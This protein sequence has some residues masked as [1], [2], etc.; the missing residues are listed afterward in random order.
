MTDVWTMIAEERAA[1]YDGLSK[2]SEEDWR[3]P[4][5]CAGWVVQDVVA[6]MTATAYT[7]QGSF[8]KNFLLS[9]FNFNRMVAKDITTYSA[10]KTPQ[11]MLVTYGTRRQSRQHPPGPTTAM[12]GECVVHSED[13]FRA[14]GSY[15]EH[16]VDHL[17]ATA[18]FYA[19]NTLLVPGKKRIAGIS[20]RAT[21]TEWQGGT[22]GSPEVSGPLV[23]L[24]M[25]MAGRKAVLEDLEGAGLE[26]LR[27]QL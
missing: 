19:K 25:A 5:L 26:Q 15:S 8:F 10:N 3:K 21:D 2:L 4:S 18:N 7:T 24:I 17:L 13:I 11:Q 9:G 14:L 27:G 1:I 6:H 23:A 22:A 16:P 12:L 20:L